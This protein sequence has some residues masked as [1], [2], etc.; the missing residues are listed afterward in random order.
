MTV[1]LQSSNASVGI[2]QA[3][4]AQGLIGLDGSPYPF[5]MNIGTCITAI[6]ASI[7]T[8]VNAKRTA[9]MTYPLRSLG[10]LSLCLQ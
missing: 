6:L 9:F 7:G 5:G 4:A 3:L 2:L 8:S 1:I 10:H